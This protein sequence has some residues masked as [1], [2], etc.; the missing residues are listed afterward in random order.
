LSEKTCVVCKQDASNK[1]RRKDPTGKYICEECAKKAA[2]AK[3][4]KNA[5]AQ[6]TAGPGRAKPPAQAPASEGLGDDFWNSK[7]QP[8]GG[9]AACPGCGTMMPGGAKICTRCGYD[10]ATGKPHRTHFSVE[11]EKK[12]RG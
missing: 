9:A 3:D 4:P 1:P 6:P 5:G 2:A 8:T 10:L 11:K 12:N 7:M